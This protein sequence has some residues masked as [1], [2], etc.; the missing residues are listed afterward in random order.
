MIQSHPY[1]ITT[2]ARKEGISLEKAA[3][4]IYHDT[5]HV[6]T[7]IAGIVTAHLS[8]GLHSICTSAA[9]KFIRT[10]AQSTQP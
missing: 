1:E 10:Y 7:T 2:Y 9:P 3:A 4:T 8:A 5:H 6:H